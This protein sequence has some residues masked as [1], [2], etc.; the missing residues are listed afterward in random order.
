MVSVLKGFFC[1]C[2]FGS[3][4]LMHYKGTQVLI[5]LKRYFGFCLLIMM[6]LMIMI[7]VSLVNVLY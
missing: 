5:G 3:F 2:V 1:V 6:C 7:D 4:F